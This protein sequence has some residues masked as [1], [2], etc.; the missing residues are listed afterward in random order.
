MSNQP[1][2]SSLI[3]WRQ[4][5]C[6]FTFFFFRNCNS[7]QEMQ[8][9]TFSHFF[10]QRLQFCA[11]DARGGLFPTD[12]LASASSWMTKNVQFIPGEKCMK[13]YKSSAILEKVLS[14]LTENMAS[15]IE[16]GL[17]LNSGNWPCIQFLGDILYIPALWINFF[18]G[19]IMD[20]YIDSLVKIWG[21]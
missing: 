8:E 9:M 4:W 10:L 2:S 11:I 7:V 19:F 14:F 12:W 13:I 1:H 6:I 3:G 21:T 20:C 16:P 5:R 17:A 18:G 15:Y